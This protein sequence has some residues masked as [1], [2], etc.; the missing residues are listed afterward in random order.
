M[1]VRRLIRL[2]AVKVITVRTTAQDGGHRPGI[3]SARSAGP[4]A[5]APQIHGTGLFEF[6]F[7]NLPPL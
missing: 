6:D 2:V 1:N 5:Q 7:V 4:D 3:L